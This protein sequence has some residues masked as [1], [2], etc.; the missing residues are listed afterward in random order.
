VD[1][2]TKGE[3]MIFIKI[4]LFLLWCLNFFSL[5]GNWLM[6]VVLFLFD[7]FSTTF[8][9]PISWW[10]VVILLCILGEVIEF[11]GQFVVGK[12]YGLTSKGNLGSFIG[13]ITGAILGAP[14][15]LGLGALIGG[16]VGAYAGSLVFELASGKSFSESKQAAYGAMFGKILGIVAKMSA[17]IGIIFLT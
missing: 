7:I 4:I 13:A 16:I 2:T 5:P 14:F 8:S 10:A 11:V 12:K 6:V 9:P 15:L 17:G 1:F 3:K